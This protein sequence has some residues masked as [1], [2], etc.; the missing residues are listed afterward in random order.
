[1]GAT[2]TS[3]VRS[4]PAKVKLPLKSAKELIQTRYR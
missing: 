1:M 4:G 3:N 2:V